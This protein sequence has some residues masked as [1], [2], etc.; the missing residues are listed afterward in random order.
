VTENEARSYKKRG[1][2]AT[3][4]KVGLVEALGQV[5]LEEGQIYRCQVKGYWVVGLPEPY[6]TQE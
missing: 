1:G 5:D 3:G 6:E 4:A 2:L